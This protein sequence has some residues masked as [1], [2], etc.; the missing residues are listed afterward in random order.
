MTY[1]WQCDAIESWKVWC[2][3]MALLSGSRR[4][5]TLMELYF[6]EGRGIIP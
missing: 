6:C 3:Y 1:D 2:R 5:E 4:P